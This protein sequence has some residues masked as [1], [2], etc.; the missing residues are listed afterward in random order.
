MIVI[1]VVSMKGGVGKTSATANLATALAKQ[2]GRG[3]VGV[4]DL[5]P[6]NSLHLHFGQSH[7]VTAGLSS[8]SVQGLE[9][10]EVM[11]HSEYGIDCVPYGD[12]T[13]L[14]RVA[15][16][17][18]L[19]AQPDFVQQQLQRSLLDA[20]RVVLIDTPPGPSVYLRQATQC[21]DLA[22]T[23][24]LADGGSYA[25][26]PAMESWLAEVTAERPDFHSLYLF[27]QVDGMNSL[28][29]DVIEVVRRH[30]GERVLKSVIHS[31]EAVAEALAFQQ[32]V[33]I[34][35]PYSQSTRDLENIAKQL[36]QYWAQ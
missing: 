25:T 22:I 31:D 27:N 9:W 10:R 6:Q 32:P 5:D 15:F 13:E 17:A 7:S 35:A 1:T 24:L 21:A 4:I 16:E 14:E 18:I 11:Y 30:L 12:V 2:L 33:A 3:A 28:G 19:E 23:V 20:K 34:Y 36:V 26:I 29:L 8:Q